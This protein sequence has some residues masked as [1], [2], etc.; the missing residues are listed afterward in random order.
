MKKVSVKI[1]IS[2]P[3]KEMSSEHM[4]EYAKMSPSKLRAHMK[5]EVGL[6]K[7]KLAKKK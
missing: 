4:K 2:K 5:E 1:K 7:K 6:L 3:K